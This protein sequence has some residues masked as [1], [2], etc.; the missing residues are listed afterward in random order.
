MKVLGM[1]YH[2]QSSEINPLA[3]G[4]DRIE[5]LAELRNLAVQDLGIHPEQYHQDTTVLFSNDIALCM[6]D[7]LELIH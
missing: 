4:K 7:I 6:E 1:Q 2:L 5:A 3:E